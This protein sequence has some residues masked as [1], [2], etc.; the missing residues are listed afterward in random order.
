MVWVLETDCGEDRQ[1]RALPTA[2]LSGR[3]AVSGPRAA[4][5]DAA[6]LYNSMARPRLRGR[7]SWRR[8]LLQA[9]RR[10]GGG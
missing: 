4:A 8:P 7:I 9:P 3:K 2:Q 6:P 5:T 1:I 10:A